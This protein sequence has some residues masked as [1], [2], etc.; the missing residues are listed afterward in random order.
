M[1]AVIRIGGKQLLVTEGQTFFA[2]LQE[3]ELKASFQAEEVL[4]I[5]GGSGATIGQPT[6]AGATVTLKVLDHGKHRKVKS[7][8]F[9]KRKA[10][11][12]IIGHRQPFTWLLVESI[13]A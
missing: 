2:E 5:L 10:M 1:Q 3:Q 8:R 12:K 7:I 4:A 11:H 9:K 13:S 6:V